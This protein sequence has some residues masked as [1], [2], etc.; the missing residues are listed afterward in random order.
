M[1]IYLY[2]KTHS[3]TGLKYLG[4]TTAKDPH[5]YTGSGVYWKNHLKVHGKCYTTEVIKECYSSDEVKVWG[6]YFSEL[7]EVVTAKDQNGK[8]LWANEKPELGDGGSIKG[9][10]KS[11]STKEKY[12]NKNWTDRAKSN[13]LENCYKNAAKKKGT[14]NPEHGKTIF[15]NYVDKNKEIFKK[16]WELYNVGINRQ[17]ISKKLGI[18]W[19][20]VNLAIN[21]KQDIEKLL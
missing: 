21:K 19:D 6:Q 13:R 2:V 11:E 17:Q 10:T 8:K 16:I 1:I 9:H 3:I 14:K 15:K 20:R 4:K 12:R 18:S 7:W 5:K